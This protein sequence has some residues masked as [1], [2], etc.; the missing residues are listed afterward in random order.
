MDSMT[1]LASPKLIAVGGKL[2][3][4]VRDAM[5]ETIARGNRPKNKFSKGFRMLLIRTSK[6]IETVMSVLISVMPKW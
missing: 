3:L 1:W 6:D 4:T 2:L 5:I